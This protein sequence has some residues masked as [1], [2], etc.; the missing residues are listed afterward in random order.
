MINCRYFSKAFTILLLFFVSIFSLEAQVTEMEIRIQEIFL[1]GTKANLMGEFD[2]AEEFF[3]AVLTKDPQNSMSAFELARALEKQDKNDE[4]ITY[5]KRAIEADRNNKWFKL[6][7]ADLYQKTE[8]NRAGANVYQQLVTQYP[9]YEE[10]YLKQAFFLVRDGA[11]AEAIKIYESL[12]SKI[13]INEELT[14]RKHTLLLGTGDSAGAAAELKKLIAAF[15]RSK[16]YQHLLADFYLQMNEKNKA[17]KV[18]KDIL[19]MDPNDAAAKLAI[20]GEMKKSGNDSK[21]LTSLRPIFESQE[22]GLDVKIKELIPMI[23]RVAKYSDQTLADEALQLCNILNEVHPEQAKVQSIAGDLYYYTGR[24][25]EARKHYEK[26][27]KY[28][29]T[30]YLVWEQ[31]L[32][33]QKDLGDYK[34]MLKTSEEAMDVFPNQ[35]A[36]FY[37]NGFAAGAEGDYSG[38]LSSLQQAAL[39]SSRNLPLN[40]DVK[41][42]T[43]WTYTKMKKYDKALAQLETAVKKSNGNHPQA[44]E[45]LGDLFFLQGKTKD[46]VDNWKE[47]LKIFGTKASLEKKIAEKALN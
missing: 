2:K 33:A 34:A 4:A 3:K 15:P 36:I 29:D 22:V 42:R 46:A 12:E 24:I 10:Y 7:L 38:A 47:A 11:P 17:Q 27:L 20:A 25:K 44:L 13:G 45:N 6:F 30:V 14:R 21:Y 31:L 32:Y 37:L 19:K 39:M 41:T 28:D 26:T 40:L 8:D 35:G 43:G 1:K 5:A 16:N 9:H 18:Y 23:Q